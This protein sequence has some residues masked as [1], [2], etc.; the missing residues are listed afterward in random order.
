MRYSK[1]NVGGGKSS[2]GK[3]SGLEN[4]TVGSKMRSFFINIDFGDSFGDTVFFHMMI[5]SKCDNSRQ[6]LTM[7]TKVCR[8]RSW[9]TKVCHSW[10]FPHVPAF[11][12]YIF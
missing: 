1:N 7:F 5:L 10:L 6:K 2:L 11:R 8:S 4:R 9:S 3:T 12:Y